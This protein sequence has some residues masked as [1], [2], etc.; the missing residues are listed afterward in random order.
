MPSF[1][2]N[3]VLAKCIK[4]IVL[5]STSRSTAVFQ[6]SLLN[7]CWSPKT[8]NINEAFIY[9]SFAPFIWLTTLHFAQVL[10]AK[11][12]ILHNEVHARKHHIFHKTLYHASITGYCL[13]LRFLHFSLTPPLALVID[14]CISPN[15]I[16]KHKKTEQFICHYPAS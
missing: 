3:A 8:Q 11:Q 12:C 5:Y 7:A 15:L 10:Y 6:E 16:I 14:T 4:D 13:W 9:F 1:T 2:A